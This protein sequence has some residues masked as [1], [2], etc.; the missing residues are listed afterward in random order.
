MTF[1]RIAGIGATVTLLTLP[2][3]AAAQ[4]FRGVYLGLGAGYDLPEDVTV[5]TPRPASPRP[6]LSTNGGIAGLGGIGYGF[7]NGVR[8]EMEGSIRDNGVSNITGTGAGA[9]S[10]GLRTY[11]AMANVLFD[12]DVGSPWIYPYFGGGAG[13]AQ[14]DTRDLTLNGARVTGSTG[15]LAAQAIGGLSLP[16]YGVPGLS[17]TSEYRFLAVFGNA[18]LSNGTS[19]QQQKHHDFLLGARYAFGV[20]PPPAAAAEAAPVPAAQTAARTFLVFF[21]WDKAALTDRARGIIKDAAA[22]ALRGKAARIDVAGH[23]DASGTPAHN[24]G[25]SLKRAQTV[26]AELVRD[27]VARD[28]IDIRSLADTAPAVQTGAGTREPRNRRVEIV[29]R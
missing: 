10:G 13:Y 15:H 8:V 25:L 1:G 14:S 2:G 9:A 19:L 22:E 16:V 18:A 4:P 11:G 27:G 24:Q 26:T 6:R 23:T 5:Q 12:M 28:A 17:V 21:D 3:L 29:L 20:Q 7:G